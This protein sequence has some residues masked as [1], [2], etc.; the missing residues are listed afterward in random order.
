M[1]RY[2][3]YTDRRFKIVKMSVFPNLTYRFKTIPMRTPESYFVDFDKLNI[4][5]I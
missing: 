1:K 3:M 2:A 5:F 4:K